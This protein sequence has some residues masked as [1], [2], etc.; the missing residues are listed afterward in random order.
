MRRV[1]VAVVASLSLFVWLDA[2]KSDCASPKTDL[3][4]SRVVEI[5][6]STGGIYGSTTRQ[7]K[8]PTF[9]KPKEV[10]LT[11][12]DGPMPWIT[13]SILDT[14]DRYCT[15]ATFFEV[16]RMA[17]E[18]Q[19]VTQEVVARGHTLGTHTMTHPFNLPRMTEKAAADEIERGFAAVAMAAGVPIAPF[20]RFPGLSDSAGL[21][22]YMR[23]R[24]VAAFTVD[25]V[26]NDSYIADKSR[27]ISR[28]LAGIEQHQGGIILFHDIKSV[29]AKA[30]PDILTAL[31]ARGY[32]VVQLRA[33]SSVQLLPEAVADVTVAD[34]RT[35][36]RRKLPFYA[37]VEPDRAAPTA[38]LRGY[39]RKKAGTAKQSITN[40]MR[41][42]R[43]TQ[44][45][46]PRYRTNKSTP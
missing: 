13:R 39:M 9:L 21:I 3:G 15:K 29:T 1:R 38:A 24:G 11:F 2:A 5:D 40:E 27:L 46:H 8:Q 19:A 36:R 37:S 10:V 30:L 31:K 45:A 42:Q 32:S 22:E 28:T 35:R 12:D 20:F 6:T 41:H 43:K 26:S 4:V 44:A 14:L 25:V 18:H 17:L 34:G 23:T 33:K 16:G 7:T